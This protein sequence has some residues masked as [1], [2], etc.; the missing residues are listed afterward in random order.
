M[1]KYIYQRNL[2]IILMDTFEYNQMLPSFFG[3]A[4]DSTIVD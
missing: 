4:P 1:I 3:V 2:I